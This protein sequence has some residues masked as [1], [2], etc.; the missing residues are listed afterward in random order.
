[1][2]LCGQNAKCT[3]LE[4][5]Y[6]CSCQVGFEEKLVPQPFVPSLSRSFD[7]SSPSTRKVVCVDVDECSQGACGPCADCCNNEGSY[8]CKCS[9]GFVGN[10]PSQPCEDIDECQRN[11]CGP[12]S[13]CM[14]VAPG[15]FCMC[16]DGFEGNGYDGCFIG[17]KQTTCVSSGECVQHSLCS[18][19]SCVCKN[20]FQE[21]GPICVD[22]DECLHQAL[23]CGTNSI[24]TNTLGGFMC[25]CK[26][27]F[28][29]YPP[30]F[31]CVANNPCKRDCGDNASCQECDGG[32]YE[33]VCNEGFMDIPG[34]GCGR[35]N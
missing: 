26:P 24:C 4:G 6:E 5:K 15:F 34:L 9:P 32:V 30:S 8:S 21:E 35:V 25:E 28:V 3:N 7:V 12:N 16:P 14:N 33:C 17:V 1:M 27:G 23:H 20:G 19:G 31:N 22:I 11:L 13:I 29:K 2:D 18:S 10:L